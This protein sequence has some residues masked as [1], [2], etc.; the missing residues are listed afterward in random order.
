MFLNN[1][2]GRCTIWLPN[3]ISFLMFI[4]MKELFREKQNED[5]EDEIVTKPS[6]RF[7]SMKKWMSF[8]SESASQNKFYFF[9]WAKSNFFLEVLHFGS[10]GQSQVFVLSL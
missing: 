5:E 2:Q 1:E 6:L 4:C 3:G 8:E 9:E 7:P 10:V